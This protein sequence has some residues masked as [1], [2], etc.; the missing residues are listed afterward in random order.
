M[1]VMEN[2]ISRQEEEMLWDWSNFFSQT[3]LMSICMI[4]LPN[5]FL[6]EVHVP[7]PMD[8]SDLKNRWIFYISLVIVINLERRSGILWNTRSQFLLNTILSGSIQKGSC[9]L[10]RM[11]T[12]MRR[13]CSPNPKSA[14]QN[15]HDRY[16]G[17]WFPISKLNA[18]VQ[19]KDPLT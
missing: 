17:M 15:D 18:C 6:T 13:N 4:R 8:V 1:A 10:D 14:H 11:S 19:R 3:S 9:S 5:H 16:T 12:V 2:S 7:I